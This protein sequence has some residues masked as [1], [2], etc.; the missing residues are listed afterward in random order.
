[1]R[2][3]NHDPGIRSMI[4]VVRMTNNDEQWKMSLRFEHLTE[5]RSEWRVRPAK[6]PEKDPN[7]SGVTR[8]SIP[9]PN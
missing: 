5:P 3:N 4:H 6:F 9:R 1:M 2:E 8:H 7:A